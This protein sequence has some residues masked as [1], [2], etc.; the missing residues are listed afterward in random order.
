MRTGASGGPSVGTQLSSEGT[1]GSAEGVAS[2]RF[3]RLCWFALPANHRHDK[4]FIECLQWPQAPARP[5][6]SHCLSF[7]GML[8]EHLPFSKTPF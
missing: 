4:F 5:C 2:L 1:A 3:A 7:P 8:S 6:V